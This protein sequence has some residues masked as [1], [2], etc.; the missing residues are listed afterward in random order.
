MLIFLRLYLDCKFSGWGSQIP[1]SFVRLK[2]GNWTLQ[3]GF[4]MKVLD[5]ILMLNNT[6]AMVGVHQ[7]EG[8]NLGFIPKLLNLQWRIKNF[9]DGGCQL[10]RWGLQ[11]VIWSNISRKLHGNE[12]I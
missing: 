2:I 8:E 11:L 3:L 10:Q 6:D 9:P 1:D 7:W 5:L 4:I 12:R